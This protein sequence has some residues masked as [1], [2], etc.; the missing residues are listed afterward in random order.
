MSSPQVNGD[1]PHSAFIDH[2]LNYPVIDSTVK[3][4]KSNPYGQRSL[5]LSDSA[6]KTFAQPVLPFL[7]K[8]Y[9]YVSPYVKK[10]DDLGAKTLSTIDSRFPV[11]K[12]PAA[13]IY[14]DAR[15]LVLYPYRTGLA[16]KDHVFETYDG[17][18]KKV[19]G[20]GLVTYGKALVTTTL[21]VATEVVQAVS[22]FLGQK[23]EVTK[24]VGD[25]KV[26]N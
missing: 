11:V 14:N 8:P 10:A 22:G 24:S 23:K 25:E 16:G 17:E 12:K 26:N 18:C 20:E 4:F 9:Q 1:V 15:D 21:I 6:Y 13:D 7:T 19:G 2:L 3:S 5:Q